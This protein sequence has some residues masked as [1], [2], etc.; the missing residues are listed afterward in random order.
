[1]IFV[2]IEYGK[3]MSFNG[4]WYRNNSDEQWFKIF[5]NHKEAVVFAKKMSDE[6][7][8]MLA[9]I[10][11]HEGNTIEYIRNEVYAVQTSQNQIVG[12][13]KVLIQKIF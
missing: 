4:T 2:D 9:Q 3:V 1:M 7:P 12:T 5:D 8:N 11:D 6:K 10:C 13:H